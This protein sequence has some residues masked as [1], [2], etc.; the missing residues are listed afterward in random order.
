[1]LKQYLNVEGRRE[2]LFVDYEYRYRSK[3]DKEAG[4]GV[5]YKDARDEN[6]DTLNMFF[7]LL[8]MTFHDALKNDASEP[9]WYH[10]AVNQLRS[11]ADF[12]RV[13]TERMDIAAS[14]RDRVNRNNDLSL[15][16]AQAFAQ[17]EE[18]SNDE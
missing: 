7:S 8:I 14:A 9:A 16:F 17:L 4:E 12:I 15:L 2:L 5:R 1:M 6:L 11:D 10:K 3:A 13:C 18:V